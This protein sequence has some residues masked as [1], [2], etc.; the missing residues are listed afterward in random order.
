[1]EERSEKGRWK[2]LERIKGGGGQTRN[3]EVVVAGAV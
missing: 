3:W 2:K 1:M